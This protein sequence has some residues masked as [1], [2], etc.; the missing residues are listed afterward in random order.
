MIRT[1]FAL[2][3]FALMVASARSSDAYSVYITFGYTS[4]TWTMYAQTD[5]PGGIAALAVNL[6][7]T[8]TATSIAPRGRMFG[9][10]TTGFTVGNGFYFGKQIFTG[11]NVLQNRSPDVENL[12][13]GV[14]H[15]PV[16]NSSFAQPSL[17]ITMVGTANVVPVPLY[18]GTW[19]SS[20]PQ[21]NFL[22]IGKAAVFPTAGTPGNFPQP[23]LA[24][25]QV[26]IPMGGGPAAAAPELPSAGEFCGDP[27][28]ANAPLPG[29][30]DGDDDIDGADFV[31]WEVYF[32]TASGAMGPGDADLDGD[33]DGEDYIVMITTVV[34]EPAAGWLIGGAM[35]VLV[36][37]TY[38][39]R[40]RWT[41]C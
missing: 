36:G 31:V 30:F 7:G 10:D 29:D 39:R 13:F 14:G 32:P 6:T 3:A 23:V 1:C 27:P 22:N 26:I 34:P 41:D 17:P 4:T 33:V 2:A 9:F 40:A 21:V 38:A 19:F 18:S 15:V 20:P 37:A 24:E 11:Q 25:L 8:S 16:P 35:L 12:V 28:V 5:A